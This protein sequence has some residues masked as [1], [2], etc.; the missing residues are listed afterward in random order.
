M[1]FPWAAKA[2]TRTVRRR[3]HASSAPCPRRN[4]LTLLVLVAVS[5]TAFF[6]D[7]PVARAEPPRT[8][9]PQAATQFVTP[10]SGS[11]AL[12]Q[13]NG[14]AM[15]IMQN[16]QKVILNW[17]NFNIGRDASVTFNQ[18]D[19]SSSALNRIA[20]GSPSQIFGK[21]SANGQIYLL[22]QN[23]IIFGNSAVVDT[24]ALVASTLNISDAN[25]LNGLTN[26]IN[27]NNSAFVADSTM[28]PQASI[29]VQSGAVLKTDE[30]GRIMIL[31]PRVENAGEIDTPGGQAIL[32][33]SQD[34]VY[35]AASGD[36]NLRGLLVEV[37]TGGTVDNLGKIVAER[38]NVS[39]LG[40]AVNQD[41]IVRATTSVNLNGSIRLVAQDQASV[42]VSSDGVGSAQATHTGSLSLGE[43]SLTEVTADDLS[44]TA[45]DVC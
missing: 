2:N 22:N 14:N 40:L 17:Q 15:T 30:G 21:L 34:K 28:D 4:S 9:L 35:L 38:G 42:T 33:A 1:S 24:H 7:S 10:G 39:L 29:A 43:N 25:F 27:Q 13:M 36:P 6:V 44:Q 11:A 5:T 37:K 8:E 20:Q 41:G 45:A 18:P 3:A 23:G 12:P 31:A 16:S 26:V 19:S 32:A